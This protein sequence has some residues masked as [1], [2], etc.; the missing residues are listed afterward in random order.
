MISAG[1]AFVLG[2]ALGAGVGLWITALVATDSRAAERA[3]AAWEERQRWARGLRSMARTTLSYGRTSDA[4][5][6]RHVALRIE[7]NDL[8]EDA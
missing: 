2:M 5:A 3:N 6:L 8:P 1:I 4:A 7:N